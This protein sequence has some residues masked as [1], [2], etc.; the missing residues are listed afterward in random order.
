MAEPS[1]IEELTDNVKEYIN[2]RVELVKL[3]ATN[4]VSILIAILEFGLIAFLLVQLILIVAGLALGYYLSSVTGSTFLG[5]LLV[6]GLYI[7]MGI[8]LVTYRKKLIINP[9]RNI[10]I[11]YILSDEK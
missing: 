4:K 7:I 5:F 3:Q 2:I 9:I 1:K 8:V 6:T 11:K 10:I